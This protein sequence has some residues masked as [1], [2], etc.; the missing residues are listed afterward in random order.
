MLAMQS[1]LSLQSLQSLIAQEVRHSYRLARGRDALG[2]SETP[3]RML[4]LTPEG[5]SYRVV[6]KATVTRLPIRVLATKSKGWHEL[7][8]AL[9]RGGIQPGYEAQLSFDS[10]T[11][12]SNPTVPPAHPWRGKNQGTIVITE[13]TNDRALY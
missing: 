1:L 9:A 7:S 11:Y 2:T 12:P 13:S 6:T 3:A 10:K 5:G 8:V 4:I